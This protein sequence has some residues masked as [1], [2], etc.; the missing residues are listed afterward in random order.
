MTT[1]TNFQ[2]STV[3]PFQF[4]PTLDGQ[5]YNATV[6]WLLFGARYYLRLTALNGTLVLQTALVG[7]PSGIALQSISWA[8]GYAMA[9]ADVPHGYKVGRTVTLTISG[10]SPAAY[11]GQV[12]AII[13][14]PNTFSWALP[15]DPGMATVFG[16]A[17]YNINLVGGYFVTS[18]LVFRQRNQQFEVTP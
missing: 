16:M 2:P 3:Q 7:S 12:A 17:S 6:P 8:N 9:T 13:T 14:G 15:T 10:A 1:F 4:S 18:T 11:N 5:V